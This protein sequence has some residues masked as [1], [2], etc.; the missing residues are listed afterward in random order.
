MWLNGRSMGLRTKLHYRFE[1][2]RRLTL[3]KVLVFPLV[4]YLVFMLLRYWSFFVSVSDYPS[5]V[6]IQNCNCNYVWRSVML[7]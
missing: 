6:I 3:L 2:A 4:S 5:F 1:A 7:H